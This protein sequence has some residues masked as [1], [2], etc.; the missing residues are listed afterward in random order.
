VNLARSFD[1]PFDFLVDA[2]NRA[3]RALGIAKKAH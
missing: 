1:V 2:N 3:A